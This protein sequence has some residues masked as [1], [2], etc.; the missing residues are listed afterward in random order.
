MNAGSQLAYFMGGGRKLTSQL[1]LLYRINSIFY[2]YSE[3]SIN[4]QL[5]FRPLLFAD[6]IKNGKFP[7][8]GRLGPNSIFIT[9]FAVI[10]PQ[11]QYFLV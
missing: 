10:M 5:D 1:F 8:Y 3:E 6:I 11:M 7:I 4:L 2:I 9:K